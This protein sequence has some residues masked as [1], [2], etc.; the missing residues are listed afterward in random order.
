MRL[1]QIAWAHEQQQQ[2]Q[3][4]Q[5][6]HLQGRFPGADKGVRTALTAST[7]RQR[8]PLPSSLFWCCVVVADDVATAAAAASDDAIMLQARASASV[9]RILTRLPSASSPSLSLS[10]TA[11]CSSISH[12]ACRS[13][14][15]QSLLHSPL[16]RS[17]RS[18]LINCN[19]FPLVLLLLLLLLELLLLLAPDLTAATAQAAAITE[20]SPT[21]GPPLPMKFSP[22]SKGVLERA[23]TTISAPAFT[24]RLVS[25]H[26]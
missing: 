17:L 25:Y 4:Q 13:F 19:E 6:A 9:T 24:S 20:C 12:T 14:S 5:I 10:A 15:Y 8:Q 23:S 2:Q 7:E 26:S 1:P 22:M 3:Q 11:S 21:A 18:S 16:S